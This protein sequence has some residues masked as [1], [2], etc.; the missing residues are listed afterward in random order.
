MHIYIRQKHMNNVI[1]L[2]KSIKY[3]LLIYIRI[4][5]AV[6]F[7]IAFPVFL[8]I[9]FGNIWGANEGY[10]PFLLSGI[11]GMTIASDGLFAVGPVIKEYYANGL[12]KYFRKL[13]FN[14]LL[15]FAGLIISRIMSLIFTILILCIITYLVFGYRVSIKEFLYYI[16]GAIV[17][18]T[19]F[20]FIGLSLSFSGI[21]G[22]A[23]KGL[24]NLIYFIILFT[25]VAFYP[26]KSFNKVIGMIGDYLPLNPILSILRNEEANYIILLFW[27]IFPIIIFYIIFYK[28]KFSR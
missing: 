12:I 14:I 13:P 4:K 20:S 8:V 5:Q 18:L 10:I 22:G 2:A 11:I 27:L 3:Q 26:V 23:D 1:I 9:I 25:S 15:H 19:V 21:K 7:S 6:F 28:I 17:G 24:S 16:M